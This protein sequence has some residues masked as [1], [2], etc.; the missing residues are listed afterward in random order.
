MVTDLTKGDPFR[1][2]WRFSIPMLLSMAF[3]QMY[4]LADGMIAGR[5]IGMDALGAVGA[6]H[7]ITTLFLSAASGSAMGVSV[8]VSQQFGAGN[9]KN[10]H[11]SVSTA[12]RWLMTLAAV[13]TVVGLPLSGGLLQLLGTPQELMKA[14]RLYL[15]I[16]VLGIPFLFLYNFANGTFNALGDSKTP[17]YFLIFSSLLNIVLD[18]VLVVQFKMGIFG[19][20]FATWLAQAI[21]GVLA[22]LLV[23]R[24]VR[25]LCPPVEQRFDR[26]LFKEMLRIGIPSV[27]QQ[28]CT[29]LGQMSIQSVI[30]SYGHTVVAGYSAAFKLNALVVMAMNTL[31]NA[32]SSYVAQNLGA[33]NL[34]RIKQGVRAGAKMMFGLAVLVTVSLL[35]GGSFWI[36]IFMEKSPDMQA[37][38]AGTSFLYIVSPFYLMVCFKVVTD[39]ALRGIGAMKEFMIANFADLIMRVIFS[40]IMSKLFGYLGIWWVWPM[41]WVVGTSLSVGFYFKKMRFFNSL[42]DMT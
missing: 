10:V 2:I 36:K 29:S 23:L 34:T 37:V 24:R 8:V 20:G 6:S 35:A 38:A 15:Q 17:L 13:L 40:I 26:G 39:G 25:L 18:I 19:I 32:I 14:A 27:I 9:L 16:Y 3:Q 33:K 42:C 11:C 30:N 31:S 7:S 41:A 28:S 12:V 4:Q 21:A 5:Y 22:T 1:T